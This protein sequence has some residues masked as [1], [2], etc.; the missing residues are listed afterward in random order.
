[1][2]EPGRQGDGEPKGHGEDGDCQDLRGSG[3]GDQ[4]DSGAGPQASAHERFVNYLLAGEGVCGGGLVVGVDDAE[5][6]QAGSGYAHGLAHLGDAAL[7]PGI[8][9]QSSGEDEN[10]EHI[11]GD[12]GDDEYRQRDG[13]GDDDV[14]PD[15]GDGGDDEEIQGRILYPSDKAEVDEAAFVEVVVE[16]LDT[17]AAYHAQREERKAG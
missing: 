7:E 5:K 8:G 4:G 14:E 17:E 9:E 16:E 1:M 6:Q 3:D 2:K 15:H 11:P 10:A 13:G 12:P